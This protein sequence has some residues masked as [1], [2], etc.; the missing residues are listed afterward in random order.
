MGDRGRLVL[1][2]KIRKSLGLKPGDLLL[3][4][5]IDGSVRLTPRAVLARRDRGAFAKFAKR[6]R[7]IVDELIAERRA[8]AIRETE[9]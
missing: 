7:S 8:E 6:G 2:A 4:E 5:V 9:E 3:A 1:P